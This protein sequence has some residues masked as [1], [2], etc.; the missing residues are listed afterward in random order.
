M[1]KSGGKS[2]EE[3]DRGGKGRKP[4][5]GDRRNT[6]G[7]IR[8]GNGGNR[9][10]EKAGGRDRRIGTYIAGHSWRLSWLWCRH[11]PGVGADPPHVAIGVDSVVLSLPLPVGRAERSLLEKHNKT[12]ANLGNE[13][14]ADSRTTAEAG[15]GNVGADWGVANDGCLRLRPR[16]APGKRR[17][18][19]S[20]RWVRY[21]R[22]PS[23]TPTQVDNC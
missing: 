1:R 14:E 2:G 22:C 15:Y 21:K 7:E 5:W 23:R 20:R 18:E 16:E 10:R 17:L 9:S 4:R 13:G 19:L 6:C 11:P 8:K 12:E 3:A